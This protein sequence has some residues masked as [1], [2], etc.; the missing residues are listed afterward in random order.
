MTSGEVLA[1]NMRGT[2]PRVTTW[3]HYSFFV[4]WVIMTL[5]MVN[6]KPVSFWYTYD[7]LR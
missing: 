4:G 3:A 5:R 1:S 6:G 2:H 7:G